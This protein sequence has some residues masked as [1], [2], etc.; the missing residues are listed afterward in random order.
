VSDEL[1]TQG[2]SDLGVAR[3]L[4]K[5]VRWLDYAYD[6]SSPGTNPN[7]RADGS[8]QPGHPYNTGIAAIF[9]GVLMLLT[10]AAVVPGPGREA[11]RRG[12]DRIRERQ[13]AARDRQS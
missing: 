12:R 6:P 7:L 9:V 5:Q 2:E 8:Y 13:G 11:V 10:L 3:Y 1:R 4:G